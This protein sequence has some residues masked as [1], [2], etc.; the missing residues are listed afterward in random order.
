[1]AVAAAFQGTCVES[2]R[3]SLAVASLL[4]APH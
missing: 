3:G 2:G 4:D 1:M